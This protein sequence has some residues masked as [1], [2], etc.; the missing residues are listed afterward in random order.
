VIATFNASNRYANARD[1]SSHAAVY[2]GQNASGVQVLDQWAGSPAAV[3]V[4]P[5]HN[6]SGVAANT[7]SAFRVVRT[8]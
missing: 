8:A 1:G 4:I 7:G 2:L 6:P 5:W 3:R